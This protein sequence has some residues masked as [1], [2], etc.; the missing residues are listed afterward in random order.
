MIKITLGYA[1][2]LSRNQ[3]LLM[4]LYKTPMPI[5]VGYNLKK[6][7]EHVGRAA[8]QVDKKQH[9]LQMF[10]ANTYGEK[11]EK[12]ELVFEGEGDDRQVKFGEGK[13]SEAG[14]YVFERL[15]PL[16]SEV[17]EIPFDRLHVEETPLQL[18][19]A[20]LELLSPIFAYAD[21]PEAAGTDEGAEPTSATQS[22]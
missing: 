10:A 5:K 19:L 17:V 15:A 4:K 11:N 9:E 6:I 16:M 21:E 12:G 8:M 2:A 1:Q 22:G 20:E 7:L 13:Q 14:K 18:N 3:E